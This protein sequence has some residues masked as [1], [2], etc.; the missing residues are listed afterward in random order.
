MSE[1]YMGSTFFFLKSVVHLTE[2][3]LRTLRSH[4][5]DRAMPALHKR[6]DYLRIY[7]YGNE[8]ICNKSRAL[9][10]VDISFSYRWVLFDFMEASESQ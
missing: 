2:G 3:N 1:A 4:D 8:V 7:Q 6:P 10:Y 9:H 5:L